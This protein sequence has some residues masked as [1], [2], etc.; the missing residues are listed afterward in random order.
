MTDGTIIWSGYNV[1]ITERKHAF[2]EIRKANAALLE[3]E[4]RFKALHNASFGG[5]VIHDNGIILEC[6]KGLSEITGFAYEELIGM[7][8]L[9]LISDDT[10]DKVLQ[11]IKTGYEKPYEAKGVRKNGEEYPLRL[12]AREIPYKGKTAR[13]VEFRDITENKRAEK[14]K[15]ELERQLVQSQKLESIGR[16]AGG[17]AHDFNNML[18]VIIGHTEMGLFKIGPDSDLYEN[19]E[20]IREATKRSA[21]L[22]HQLLAFARKQTISPKVVDL[23]KIIASTLSMLK[24]LIGEDIELKWFPC[25]EMWDVRV[26]P[27]QIDQILTNLCVNS[28]DAFKDGGDITIETD[29]VVLDKG[30][31]VNHPEIIPGEYVLLAVSDSGC[32][33]NAETLSNIF[34]PFYTTKEP[35]QGTGLGLS[36]VYGIV[37]QNQGVIDV[38]SELDKGTTFR[39]YLPRCMTK[40]ETLVSEVKK[41]SPKE[42]KETILLV[43]DE[44]AILKM[45]TSVLERF[46]Y[47]VLAADTPGK[48][49]HL[50]QDY[51][52]DI[53]LLLTDVI[54]PEMNGRDLAKN[55]L[56]FYPNI[57]RLFMSGYTAD[58]IAHHGVLDEGVNFIN[59]PFSSNALVA[60]IRE[61]LD[62]DKL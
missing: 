57:H 2:E 39:I 55:I 18:S 51:D 59:K 54:M 1:D 27:G 62:K 21:D 38:S 29:T 26:D 13:V 19:L 61:I 15:D 60:K 43:E 33:M 37:K 5:I 56:S 46:G 49:I 34:E 42:G 35:G 8:G 16:L 28:R 22:T 36:T 4:E 12:E 58:L 31:C 14:E 3:S 41:K 52:G 10:R 24:R 6:N 53:Q 50:A 17:V 7:N 32:G 23:N 20:E 9:Y 44:E 40:E 25:K 48:A 47:Q 11:N 45:I 30:Y